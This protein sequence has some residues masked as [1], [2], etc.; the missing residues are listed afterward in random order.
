MNITKN[1]T[2]VFG[3]GVIKNCVDIKNY[4]EKDLDDGFGCD[5]VLLCLRKMFLKKLFLSKDE[6]SLIVCIQLNGIG[7]GMPAECVSSWCVVILPEY[8]KSCR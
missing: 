1:V 4:I 2:I 8:G 3:K 6:C 7:L 5:L